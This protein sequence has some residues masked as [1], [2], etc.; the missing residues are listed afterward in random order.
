M[1]FNCSRG[2]NGDQAEDGLVDTHGRNP[3]FAFPSTQETSWAQLSMSNPRAW[4][5]GRNRR[6]PAAHRPASLGNQGTSGLEESLCRDIKE[7]T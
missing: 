3:E 1:A 4:D 6:I 2:F 7:D 5:E